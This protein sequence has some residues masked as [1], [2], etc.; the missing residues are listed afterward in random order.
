[1]SRLFLA[2]AFVLVL[3]C[4]EVKEI[5]LF[6]DCS[7]LYEENVLLKIKVEE[8]EAK[9]KSEKFWKDSY[10]VF[11]VGKLAEH[12]EYCDFNWGFPKRKK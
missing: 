4:G 1:M 10:N 2:V 11:W 6:Q 12:E 9:A 5:V 8:A 7:A 3:G